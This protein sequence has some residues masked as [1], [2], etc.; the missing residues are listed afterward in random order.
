LSSFCGLGGH[1]CGLD[2]PSVVDVDVH[3]VAHTFGDVERSGGLCLVTV[4][5]VWDG[6]RYDDDGWETFEIGPCVHR[7]VT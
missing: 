5:C 1:G 4:R 2:Y 6:C 3:R 7:G